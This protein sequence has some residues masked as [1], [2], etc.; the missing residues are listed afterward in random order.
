MNC[1]ICGLAHKP[2]TA[3]VDAMKEN[4]IKFLHRIAK[5]QNCQGCGA[6]VFFIH[7]LNGKRP[8][9]TEA[10]QNHFIDCPARETFKRA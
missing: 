9:Y 2:E 10:L 7:H 4:Q 3:C 8:P 6:I 1:K 5:P